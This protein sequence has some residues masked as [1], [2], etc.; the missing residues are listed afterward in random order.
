[1]SKRT[2]VGASNTLFKYFTKTP[3]SNKKTKLSLDGED[4]ESKLKSVE[5]NDRDTKTESK[6]NFVI[7]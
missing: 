6:Y 7:L 4:S 2:S 1:M 3:P 5:I